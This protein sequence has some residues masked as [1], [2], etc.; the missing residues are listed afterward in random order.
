MPD[1][2][3]CGIEHVP[4]LHSAVI[5]IRGWLRGRLAK[6]GPVS[7][8]E[9][10]TEHA[11]RVSAVA[12]DAP[13]CAPEAAGSIEKPRVSRTKG[14]G[15]P[16]APTGGKRGHRSWNKMAHVTAERI[17]ELQQTG[18][19]ASAIAQRLGCT[20][21][22]VY[23]RL[24]VFRRSSPEASRADDALR[25]CGCGRR[26]RPTNAACTWCKTGRTR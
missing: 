13:C 4:E 12:P 8:A 6:L 3:V 14:A 10:K 26:K 2:S 16:K 21:D 11:P 17:M 25:T 20:R 9:P 22:T 15:K 19:A 7:P 5:S 24:R 18:M 23:D 1:C